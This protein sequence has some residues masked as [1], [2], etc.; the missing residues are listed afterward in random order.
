MALVAFLYREK[1]LASRVKNYLASV[2]FAQ[3][4]LELG[5]THMGGMPHL[6]YVVKGFKRSLPIGPQGQRLPISLRILRQLKQV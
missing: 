5:D 6:E 3:I 4:A 2:R 1:L